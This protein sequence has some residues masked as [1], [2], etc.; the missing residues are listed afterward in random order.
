MTHVLPLPAIPSVPVAGSDDRFPVRRIFCVG[1]NYADHAREMGHDPD[2]EPPFFFSKPA[3]ALLTDDAPLPYPPRTADLHYE[4]ELVVAIGKAGR[5]I[6]MTEAAR[7]VWGYAAGNDFTRRDLQAEAKKLGRPWDMAKGFDHSAACGA[8]TPAAQAGPM[9][10]GRIMS[11]VDGVV[12]QDGDLG[13][14]IWSIP[15]IVAILSGYVGL[16][17]GDLIFTG[18]PAGVGALSRGAR[19]AVRIDGLAPLVTD[20]V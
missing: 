17:A 15:E 10:R 6:P 19:V 13:Q 5:D 9:D 16:A 8:I 1:R 3:D 20:I 14:M 4:G 12:R 7:H 11:T 18:T 2:R